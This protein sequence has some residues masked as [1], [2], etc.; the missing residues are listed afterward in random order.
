[1]TRRR[2]TFSAY[3]PLLS[4]MTAGLLLFNA[5]LF[6]FMHSPLAAQNED[7]FVPLVICTA[8]GIRTI[9]VP[10]TAPEDGNA[11][12]HNGFDGF[13]CSLCGLGSHASAMIIDPVLPSLDRLE[14]SNVAATLHITA[15]SPDFCTLASEPR[16]PPRLV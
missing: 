4:L 13:Q 9:S 14:L 2:Q 15:H 16:A 8:N 10:G 12:S 5:M 3:A 6:G 1:M 11:P 7:G